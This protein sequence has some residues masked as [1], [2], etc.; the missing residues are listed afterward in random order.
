MDHNLLFWF[1]AVFATFLVGASKGGLPLVGLLAVPMMSLVMSPVM[2]AG[3]LLPLYV[4]SDI[5]GLW[6]YRKSYSMRNLQIIV[7]AATLGIGIGWATATITSDIVV[8]LI[9]ATIGLFYFVDALLKSRRSSAAKPADIPRGL[10]WGTLAGFTSFVSH[11]G[12]PPYQMYVLPQK[13]D[14]MT[15]AGTATIAFTIINAL[16]LPPYWLLGQINL[17]SLETCLV[18]APVSLIGAWAGYRLTRVVPEKQ[19][20]RA[21]ELALLILSLLLLWDVWEHYAT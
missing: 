13:L 9:V 11:A 3:L 14:K 4:V 10:F 5:Y 1:M 17:S 21:V 18:L 19:F 12:G 20:F 6:L 7:P 8:K 16:K 15:Y 2:A